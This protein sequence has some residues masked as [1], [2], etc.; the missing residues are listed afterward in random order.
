M[1]ERREYVDDRTDIERLIAAA[2]DKA[3][4]ESEVA[5]N[6]RAI[7]NALERLEKALV[8]LRQDTNDNQARMES[9]LGRVES[10]I[11]ILANYFG[12]QSD[13]D[14]RKLR[15]LLGEVNRTKFSSA[16]HLGERIDINQKLTE[17]PRSVAER[18]SKEE[19]LDIYEAWLQTRYYYMD[20]KTRAK[21]YGGDVQKAEDNLVLVNT[22][23]AQLQR[24]RG[25]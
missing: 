16:P 23:I 14:N 7:I 5:N 17:S 21:S 6:Q 19:G 11:L 1:I 20:L 12:L 8:S 22:I 3:R 15:D 13:S 4:A 2:E 25:Q 24:E 10:S 18:I 9:T